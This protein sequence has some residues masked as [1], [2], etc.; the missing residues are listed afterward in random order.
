VKLCKL[1]AMHIRMNNHMS[2]KKVNMRIDEAL[3]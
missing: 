3:I 1:N 2:D